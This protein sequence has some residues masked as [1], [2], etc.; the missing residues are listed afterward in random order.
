VP[1]LA[2]EI[3]SESDTYNAMLRKKDRY[4]RAGTLEV[5]LI[6]TA[7][8]EI[9][10]YMHGEARIQSRI[11]VPGDTLSSDLLAGF[12]VPVDELFVNIP[13]EPLDNT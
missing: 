4:L 8:R 7:T 5:W 13:V 2:I 12:S 1:D 6:S 11:L 9:T 10:I 3:A